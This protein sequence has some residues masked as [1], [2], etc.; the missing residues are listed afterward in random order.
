M[1][2]DHRNRSSGTRW[3]ESRTTPSSGMVG[4]WPTGHRFV[5]AIG[6]LWVQDGLLL[7]MALGF[8]ALLCIGCTSKTTPRTPSVTPS[9]P[10][11][12]PSIW[13]V[14]S[15]TACRMPIG[16]GGARRLVEQTRKRR[17]GFYEDRFERA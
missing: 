14:C 8:R 5:A 6:E 4:K 17:R 16:L 2:L 12:A 9:V 15:A 1:A 11:S 3:A 7:L 10:M 13:P